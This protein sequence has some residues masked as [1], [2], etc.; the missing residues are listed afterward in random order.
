MSEHTTHKV[1]TEA[2]TFYVRI[3]AAKRGTYYQDGQ[4]VEEITPRARISTDP[5]FESDVELGYVKI[6]GRKYSIEH[7][8]KRMRGWETE[9]ESREPYWQTETGY[10]SGYRNDKGNLVSYEAKAYG[11]LRDMESAALD[12]FV[13]EH[14]DWVRESTRRLFEQERNHLLSKAETARQEAA[15]HEIEASKW[16]ARIDE[17]VAA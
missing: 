6:R 5:T 9:H 14:S 2:G 13:E 1:E 17:L 11:Q 16:Q 4:T 10:R 15:K 3:L 12:R 7:T 8:V